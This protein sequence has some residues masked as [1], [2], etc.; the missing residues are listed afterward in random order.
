MRKGQLILRR[1]ASF[2]VLIDDQLAAL[3]RFHDEPRPWSERPSIQASQ[4]L[5]EFLGLIQLREEFLLL[6]KGRRMDH[7]PA[8]AQLDR[9]SQV[10]HLMINKVFDCEARRRGAVK[11]PAYHDGVVRRIIVAQAAQG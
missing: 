4:M 1:R 5:E 11:D 6:L 2:L 7:P 9:M 3:L 10:Q 8:P